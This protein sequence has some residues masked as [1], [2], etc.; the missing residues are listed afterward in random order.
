[1][2]SSSLY[3]HVF[4]V[5][6]VVEGKLLTPFLIMQFVRNFYLIWNC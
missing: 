4:G 3:W 5:E 6:Q 1:M 2:K